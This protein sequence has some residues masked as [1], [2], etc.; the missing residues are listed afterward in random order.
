M[1]SISS[2][3]PSNSE[4]TFLATINGALSNLSLA[5][6]DTNM[7]IVELLDY[8][9]NDLKGNMIDII[10]LTMLFGM[11]DIAVQSNFVSF[12]L[13]FDI[14][15]RALH[16]PCCQRSICALVRVWPVTP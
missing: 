10:V 4:P 11:S 9:D 8:E 13:R 14:A 15:A 1:S 16:R 6:N 5:M 7:W 2:S 12:E 3:I